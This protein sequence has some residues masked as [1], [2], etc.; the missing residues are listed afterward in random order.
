VRLDG[1]A[2]DPLRG[3]FA[4]GRDLTINYMACGIKKAA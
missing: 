1:V 2:Y 4:L 3:R